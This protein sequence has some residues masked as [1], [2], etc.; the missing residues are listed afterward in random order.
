M[1]AAAMKN[2]IQAELETTLAHLISIPS[3]SSN[4]VACHEIIN[5][6]RGELES[7]NV[8]ITSDTERDNPWILATTQ[9]TKEPDILL[10]AHLDVVPG[11]VDLFTM[12]KQGDKL[13]GRGTYDMKFAAACYLVFAK[14]HAHALRKL[15]IGFLF[16]TDEELNGACMPG[17]LEMGL[18][19][20]IVFLPDG[21]DNWHV[22][23]R[24]KGLYSLEMI[25]RGAT[26]HGSRPWEGDNALHRIMD[27][28]NELRSIFPHEHADT[29][30]LAVTQVTGG[31]AVNQIADFASAKIDFRSFHRDD[32]QFL[33]SELERLVVQ[34]DIEVIP[35]N[36]GDPLAFDK[37]APAS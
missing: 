34:H 17:I 8:F 21:G 10:A 15:N 7:L 4:A 12:K 14:Q 30:T 1:G 27:V 26:A 16:T 37:D 29:S 9:D 32:I 20:G 31:T 35:I 23:E 22:E 28:L 19:P 2:S 6:V 33:R 5:H 24:A 11:E 25:A 13:V 18:R 36:D 3:V